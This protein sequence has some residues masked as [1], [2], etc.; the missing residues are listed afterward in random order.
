MGEGDVGPEPAPPAPHI[1]QVTWMVRSVLQQCLL[2]VPGGV[3]TREASPPA[4]VPKRG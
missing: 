4:L 3:L 2:R 1:S